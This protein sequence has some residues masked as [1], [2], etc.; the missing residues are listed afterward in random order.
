VL[1]GIRGDQ[2]AAIS[3]GEV[4]VGKAVSIRVSD[5]QRSSLE[6]WAKN[7]AGTSAQWI[8]RCSIILLAAEAVPLDVR[9]P[10][11]GG[12]NIAS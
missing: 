12:M 11:A 3:S 6:R 4:D 8:E 2:T 5:R 10:A 7:K 9:G 1:T